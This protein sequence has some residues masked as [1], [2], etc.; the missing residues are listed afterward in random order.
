MNS[1][2]SQQVLD[3]ALLPNAGAQEGYRGTC[4][5]HF[6]FNTPTSLE[7]CSE[8]GFAFPF[9]CPCNDFSFT[10]PLIPAA[11]DQVVLHEISSV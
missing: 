11:C 3:A 9:I 7:M 8:L 10:V 5:C 6:I 2:E 1:G 4:C